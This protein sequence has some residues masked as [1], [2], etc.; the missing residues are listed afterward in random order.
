MRLRHWILDTM[1]TSPPDHMIN[2]DDWNFVQTMLRRRTHS[3][4]DL[5]ASM[6]IQMLRTRYL[7]R[8]WRWWEDY[9]YKG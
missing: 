4:F 2:P 3:L 1:S 5:L 8:Q 6:D 9:G 7:S